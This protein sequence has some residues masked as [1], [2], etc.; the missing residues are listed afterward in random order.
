VVGDPHPRI[1]IIEGKVN[2]AVTV[3]TTV[4]VTVVMVMIATAEHE[5]VGNPIVIVIVIVI[6]ITMNS[7]EIEIEGTMMIRILIRTAII[8]AERARAPDLV[9]AIDTLPA[10]EIPIE[11]PIEIDEAETLLAIVLAVV[12]GNMNIPVRIRH[13][14][15]ILLIVIVMSIAREVQ[16]QVDRILH[17]AR[18]AEARAEALAKAK[19]LV[20]AEVEVAVAADQDRYLLVRIPPNNRKRRRKRSS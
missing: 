12:E 9:R 20:G 3:I 13:E 1:I 18:R 19:A 15:G 10:A 7:N 16:V 11:I 8:V 5:V 17:P 2:V 6:V 4:T 14:G